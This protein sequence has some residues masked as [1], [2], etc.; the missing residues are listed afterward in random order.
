MKIASDSFW[1]CSNRG[2]F[3]SRY[4]Q[5]YACIFGR[6][7]SN[8]FARHAHKKLLEWKLLPWC[9]ILCGTVMPSK[10]EAGLMQAGGTGAELECL[11]GGVIDPLRMSS[12]HSII[13]RALTLTSQIALS[14]SHDLYILGVH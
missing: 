7:H 9:G 10:I 13:E 2:L 1:D 11:Q 5:V 4:L 6:W 14:F 3:G 8:R 12:L